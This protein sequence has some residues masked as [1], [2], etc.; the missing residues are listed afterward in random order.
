MVFQT[1][2]IAKLT[3]KAAVELVMNN[4]ITDSISIAGLLKVARLK[5]V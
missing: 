1:S 4:Q 5:G 2:G 3:L